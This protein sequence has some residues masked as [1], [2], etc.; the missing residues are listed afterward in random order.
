MLL[1]SYDSVLSCCISKRFRWSKEGDALNYDIYNRPR[2]Q[3]YEGDL[4]ENGAFYISLIKE[5]KKTRNRI[6]GKIGIC[7]MP[8]YTSIE[9]DEPD[10]WRI[11]ELLFTKYC[12]QQELDVSKIKIFL[13]DVDGVLTDGG[14]YYSKEGDK[15]KKFCTH[16]GMGLHKLQEKGVKV[17]IITSE[18]T[19]I[20]RK[21][22]IANHIGT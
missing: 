6:S 16:D 22:I 3:D 18:D 19:E 10:D 14:M 7:Q 17:G 21:T 20:N 9:V 13:S 8:E 5:I 11:A 4:I 1:K 15:M 2:R 12:I